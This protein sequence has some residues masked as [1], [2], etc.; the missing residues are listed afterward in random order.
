MAKSAMKPNSTATPAEAVREAAVPEG[1]L[2]LSVGTGE[3]MTGSNAPE[4]KPE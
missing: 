1:S 2:P 3:S 4:Q